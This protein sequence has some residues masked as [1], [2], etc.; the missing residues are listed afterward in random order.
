MVTSLWAGSPVA[1]A[2]GASENGFYVDY[3]LGSPDPTRGTTAA[4]YHTHPRGLALPS[5]ED[6]EFSR[7]Y[8]VPGFIWGR[9]PTFGGGGPHVVA[10]FSGRKDRATEDLGICPL[11]PDLPPGL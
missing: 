5:P 10:T 1:A 2:R 8:G 11:P 7:Y 6:R 9:R 3:V 4:W